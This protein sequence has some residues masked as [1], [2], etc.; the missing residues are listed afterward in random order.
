MAKDLAIIL[1]SVLMLALL[2]FCLYW[3]VTTLFRIEGQ[4]DF[5]NWLACLFIF[6]FFRGKRLE[7]DK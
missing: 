5:W 1:E 7:K 6:W 2:P 4:F 3:S